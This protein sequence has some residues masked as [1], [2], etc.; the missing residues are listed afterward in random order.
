M[1]ISIY[2][3]T[4][5]FSWDKDCGKQHLLCNICINYTPKYLGLQP[6]YSLLKVPGGGEDLNILSRRLSGL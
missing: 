6:Q 1:Y 3:D 4:D 2:K 5:T